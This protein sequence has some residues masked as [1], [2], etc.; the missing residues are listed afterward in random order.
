[1]NREERDFLLAEELLL[2]RHSGEIPE[3]ALHGSLH[4]LCEDSQGPRLVLSEEELRPLQEAVQARYQEIILRDLDPENRDRSLF[5]GIRRAHHNWY[6]LA[7]YC[8]QIR[9]SLEPFRTVAAEALLAYL[10]REAAEVTSGERPPSINCTAEGLLT[11][12]LALGLSP[13][14]LPDNWQLLFPQVT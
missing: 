1:M 9:R 7:R 2:V 4:F 6:R 8:Q 3:V 11:F 12:S 5:R 10:H 13:G 14:A